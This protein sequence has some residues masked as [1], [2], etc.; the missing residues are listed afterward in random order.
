M[1]HCFTFLQ[2]VL[3]LRK[4]Q[5]N[6]HY[7]QTKCSHDAIVILLYIQNVEDQGSTTGQVKSNST[8]FN[9]LVSDIVIYFSNKNL[10]LFENNLSLNAL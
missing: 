4:K 6:I 2:Q 1:M 7:L 9:V 3:F 8:C 5:Y 10:L